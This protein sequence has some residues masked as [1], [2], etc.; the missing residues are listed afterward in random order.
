MPH[1]E[2]LTRLLPPVAYQAQAE[3]VRAELVTT[4]KVLDEALASIETLMSELDPRTAYSLLEEW[5]HA[6]GLPDL[7]IDLM[8]PTVADRRLSVLQKMVARGGQS[9]AYFVAVAEALG[10]EGAVVQEYTP[11]TCIDTCVE[12]IADD[13]WRHV[14]AIQAPQSERITYFTCTSPC[15]E[16][17]ANWSAIEALS[18]VIGRLKPAHTICYIDLGA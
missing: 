7:C 16:P 14:W 4:A 9:R 8:T 1:L 5:E 3:G 6:F 12:P 11:W 18:C 15:I 2:T 17:L 13:D 10:Y